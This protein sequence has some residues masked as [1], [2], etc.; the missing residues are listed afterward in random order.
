[1]NIH[2]YDEK[3]DK[4]KS[5]NLKM[6]YIQHIFHYPNEPFNITD[7]L[8][9]PKKIL[10]KLQLINYKSVT[11]IIKC[12][13][14]RCIKTIDKKLS[15]DYKI[16]FSSIK[17][18][19]TNNNNILY[20]KIASFKHNE[21]HLI[22]HR[23]NNHNLLY[24]HI[25]KEVQNINTILLHNSNLRYSYIKISNNILFTDINKIQFSS[26]YFQHNNVINNKLIIQ[27]TAI[28]KFLIELRYNKSKRNSIDNLYNIINLNYYFNISNFQ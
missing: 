27:Y 9:L 11:K 17:Q 28:N 6:T 8:K 23:L 21:S 3:N 1:M 12:K 16:K 26:Y 20:E 14:S 7:K 4:L 13:F 25:N 5:P 2:I 10:K 18:K 19:N 22:K 24:I 15:K